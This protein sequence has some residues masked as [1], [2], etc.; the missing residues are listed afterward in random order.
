MTS[1]RKTSAVV[2]LQRRTRGSLSPAL[3]LTADTQSSVSER[4]DE[5]TA[6]EHWSSTILWKTH[7]DL[8]SG[9]V[10]FAMRHTHTDQP[11]SFTSLFLVFKRWIHGLSF[12]RGF[13]CTV[14]S[15]SNEWIPSTSAVESLLCCTFST[16]SHRCP[17]KST[18]PQSRVI[19]RG[20]WHRNNK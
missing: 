12:N 2:Y 7:T 10:R 20:I 6:A 18:I 11:S 16:W 13:A 14:P 15:F 19:T 17:W 9:K 5:N 1:P 4:A 8:Q 3:A